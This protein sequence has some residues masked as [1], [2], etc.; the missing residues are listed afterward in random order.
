MLRNP[1]PDDLPAAFTP[2]EARALGVSYR[3]TR[4]ADL[5]S[6]FHGVRIPADL[7]EDRL[8]QLRALARV[9]PHAALSHQTAATL[10][11]LPL[12]AQLQQPLPV[13]VTVPARMDRI[14]RQGVVGHAA[15]RGVVVH[16]NGLLVTD[17][18]ETWC[19]LAPL[20]TVTQLVQAGDAIINRTGWD[21]GRL[22][23][24]VD[25]ARRRR[26]CRR[27]RAALPLLRPGS[28]S[29]RESEVRVLFNSWG[30]PEPELN[31]DLY[32]VSGWLACVDFLWRDERVVA[33]Y[34][35]RVH[36]PTWEQDLA[37]AALIEDEG[38]DVVVITDG[39]LARRRDP[40]HR[41]LARLLG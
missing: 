15:D 32:N 20:L 33:E 17:L 41:R 18:G 2:A 21:L 4:A 34:Y 7:A 5:V 22:T 27:L 24:A 39:D 3:R 14:Q 10:W 11:R 23:A 30:L 8:A 37:R 1:L 13:H 36:G 35:G 26:G 9:A 31:V 25:R 29:P 19:D 40:L 38:Y 28:R 6:P 16:S 12:P